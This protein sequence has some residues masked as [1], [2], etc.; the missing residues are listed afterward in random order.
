MTTNSALLCSSFSLYIK[1]VIPTCG[2]AKS[3]GKN[4]HWKAK[5]A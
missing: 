5:K 4:S 1:T 3:E 2:Q